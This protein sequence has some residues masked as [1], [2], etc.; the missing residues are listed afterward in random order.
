MYHDQKKPSVPDMKYHADDWG[1][2][3]T[4]NRQKEKIDGL[5]YLS[6]SAF[7]GRCVE[8]YIYDGSQIFAEAKNIDTI[9]QDRWFFVDI[10]I[11]DIGRTILLVKN[12][13]ELF[14][15]LKKYNKGI[16][17]STTTFIFV[18]MI[19]KCLL[20]CSGIVFSNGEGDLRVEL[21]PDSVNT[22]DLSDGRADATKLI[23]YD[24]DVVS[25]KIQYGQGSSFNN[26]TACNFILKE[27]CKCCYK[28]K[29]YYEFIYGLDQIYNFPNL[30][31]TYYSDNERYGLKKE[32]R[33]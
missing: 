18:N 12:T 26:S 11:K 27:I 14:D 20:C 8:Y 32:N 13:A 21:M 28:N 1:I 23:Y 16:Y 5:A 2:I 22:R 29:G 25:L 7:P 10:S 24:V 4:E 6:S 9:I 3:K 30:F 31:F 33:W 19:Q 17:V 15:Q